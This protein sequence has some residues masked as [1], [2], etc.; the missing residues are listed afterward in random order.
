MNSSMLW[1]GFLPVLAFLMLDAFGSKRMALLGALGL[2]A[3]ETAYTLAAFGA[4]DYMSVV[5]FVILAVFVAASLSSKDD[6]FFKI[7]SAVINIIM[8]AAMWIAFYGFH[9]AMLLDQANK[10]LD[11]DALIKANPQLDKAMVQETFRVLS[12]QLPAWLLLHS[13]LTIYA[14]ANW[15]K[16][17]WA[18]VRVPGLIIAMVLGFAFAEATV[19]R[20]Q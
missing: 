20:A 8:A 19:L 2:G 12:Y 7:S 14:A 16:W 10:Y 9:R 4:L 17:A 1:F 5:A 15:G 6:F 13:L 3:L 18:F 11:L